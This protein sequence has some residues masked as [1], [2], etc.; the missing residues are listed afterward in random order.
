MFSQLSNK[1]YSNKMFSNYNICF[2]NIHRATNIQ[3]NDKQQLKAKSVQNNVH[4]KLIV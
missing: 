1:K 2:Y 3:I 4:A